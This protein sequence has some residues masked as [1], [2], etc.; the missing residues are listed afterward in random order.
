MEWLVDEI[1]IFV[2]P[3]CEWLLDAYYVRDRGVVFEVC[4]DSDVV[5]WDVLLGFGRNDYSVPGRLV[6]SNIE[7]SGFDGPDPVC[8]E[9]I[10]E[11]IESYCH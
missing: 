6:G 10:E 1:S 11:G 3:L 8:E 9:A 2:K 5:N 7:G 4:R